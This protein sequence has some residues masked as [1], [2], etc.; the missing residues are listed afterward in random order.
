MDSIFKIVTHVSINDGNLRRYAFHENGIWTCRRIKKSFSTNIGV[1]VSKEIKPIVMAFGGFNAHI[2]L[3]TIEV[4]PDWANELLSNRLINTKLLD[5]ALEIK[6]EQNAIESDFKCIRSHTIEYM[7]GQYWSCQDKNQ[8]PSNIKSIT[9]GQIIDFFTNQD[10][11]FDTKQYVTM[12]DMATICA[13]LMER[14]IT[15]FHN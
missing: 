13:A 12:R 5:K 11:V 3:P 14:G 2:M 9:L 4:I 10:G 1:H 15:N 8:I 6:D 7:R